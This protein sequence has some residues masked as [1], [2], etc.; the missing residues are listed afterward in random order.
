MFARLKHDG[1]SQPI[2]PDAFSTFADDSDFE[3]HDKVAEEATRMLL[4]VAVPRLA[5]AMDTQYVDDAFDMDEALSPWRAPGFEPLH[6]AVDSIA[7][8]WVERSRQPFFD[9]SLLHKFHLPEQRRA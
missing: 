3:T 9:G 5:K 8:A 2:S 6:A 7:S 1:T 4:G